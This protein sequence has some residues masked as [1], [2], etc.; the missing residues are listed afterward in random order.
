MLGHLFNSGDAARWPSSVFRG[1][2]HLVFTFVIP[3]ALMTT[4]PARALLGTLSLGSVAFSAGLA[5]VFL[6]A[7]RFILATVDREVHVDEQLMGPSASA[8][9][10]AMQKTFVRSV[11]SA[12]PLAALGSSKSI[13]GPSIESSINRCHVRSG[14]PDPLIPRS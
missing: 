14:L 3:L 5:V 12:L 13:D 11:I 4:F 6:A 1:V 10:Q 9:M 8:R 2:M 7:S